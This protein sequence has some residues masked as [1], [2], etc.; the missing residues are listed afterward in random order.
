MAV[1]RGPLN[2]RRWS[3]RW[4][5]ATNDAGIPIIVPRPV[6]ASVPSRGV[7]TEQNVPLEPTETTVPV[8]NTGRVFDVGAVL[9]RLSGVEAET[10]RTGFPEVPRAEAEAAAADLLGRVAQSGAV[11]GEQQREVERRIEQIVLG[12]EP[13]GIQRG[14]STLVGLLPDV[15]ERPLREGTA[16]AGR[17]LGQAV[18]VPFR[19]VAS[20]AK[21]ITDP[22]VEGESASLKEFVTQPFD[23]NNFNP[24]YKPIEDFADVVF[25]KDLSTNRVVQTL[26]NLLNF[27][28]RVGADPT[29]YVGLAPLKYQGAAGRN[30]AAQDFLASRTASLLDEPTRAQLSA[31]IYRY[32]P[33]A[34]PTNVRRGLTEEGLF[35]KAGVR[36]AGGVV[37]GTE[38]LGGGGA[39]ALG[40]FRAGLGD[41]FEGVPATA[42]TPASRQGLVEVARGT[43]DD[44]DRI[45]AAFATQNAALRAKA[46]AGQF[47]GALATRYQPLARALSRLNE[48][49]MSVLVDYAEG[50]IEDLATVPQN[51]RDLAGLM[52]T[53]YDESLGEYNARRIAFS[54]ANGLRLEEVPRIQNFVHRTLTDQAR[55]FTQSRRGLEA[56]RRI[57]RDFGVDLPV[58]RG[59][60]GF[61]MNR[62]IKGSFLGRKLETGPVLR[63]NA[64]GSVVRAGTIREINDI[65]LDELGFKLFDDRP[66]NVLASYLR[67]LTTQFQREAFI[68]DLFVNR[69]SAVAPL[70]G[71]GPTSKAIRSV[72]DGYTK[73]LDQLDRQIA[74]GVGRAEG[75][76][77]RTL[78]RDLVKDVA[79]TTRQIT[80]PLFGQ[81]RQARAAVRRLSAGLDALSQ[82]IA[83]VKSSAEFRRLELDQGALAVLEPLE[84]R[85]RVLQDAID[86]G[87]GAQVAAREWLLKR[88]TELFPDALVRPSA[89]AQLAD[90]ILRDAESRLSGA[91]RAGVERRAGAARE[92]ASPRPAVEVAGETT[93]LPAARAEL[94]R[95]VSAYKKEQKKYRQAIDNDPTL[96]E[97]GSLERKQARQSAKLDAKR[98]ISGTFDLWE[99]TVG[100]LWRADIASIRDLLK[101]IPR[102]DAGGRATSEWLNHVQETFSSLQVAGLTEGQQDALTRVMSQLYGEEAALAKVADNI[103]WGAEL[104]DLVTRGLI[105]TAYVEDIRQGWKTIRDLQVQVS[106]EMAEQIEGIYSGLV[107]DLDRALGQGTTL[108]GD[109]YRAV[110]LYFKSTA[111][112]SAAFTVR[113]AITATWN[114]WV[115]GV[116]VAQLND[117]FGFARL[118]KQHG[119]EGAYRR[120]PEAER[121]RFRAAMDAVYATGG[122]KNVDEI[123]PVVGRAARRR[124][125]NQLFDK[126]AAGLDYVFRP[127]AGRL[128]AWARGKNESVEIA[129]ARLPLALN[130][131]DQGYSTAVNAARI[132]RTQFDYTDLSRLDETLKLIIPFWVFA[133]RNIPLQLVNRA[134]VPGRYAAYDRAT[135]LEEENPNLAA[136]R[137]N[138]NP[139]PLFGGVLDL[140]LPMSTLEDQF[141][142]LTSLSGLL[143]QTYPMVRSPIEFAT[144]QRIA[145]GSAYPYGE[146]FEPLR[147]SV[148]DLPAT[149][150]ALLTGGTQRNVEG[151][152]VAPSRVSGPIRSS[153][154]AFQ[155]IQ[156]YGALLIMAAGGDETSQLNRLVGAEE[157]FFDR[158]LQNLAAQLSGFNYYVPTPED[159]S[160]ESR[161]MIGQTG[162]L[163]REL[164]ELGVIP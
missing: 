29:T 120:V 11:G 12:D 105:D 74:S 65:S 5:P 140:D 159:I 6:S 135:E 16:A 32:G 28:V 119:L 3:T 53:A 99:N 163:E 63:T 125:K 143:G 50:G 45:L 124:F 154:P 115:N 123:F 127:F 138:R 75:A 40:R 20:Y 158:D 2:D 37:P 80:G 19:A 111:V 58:M 56:A 141:A 156:R 147:P 41:V 59:Q 46:D 149:V 101:D 76:A 91:A 146:G 17:T 131:V 4:E 13:T 69:P 157:R 71:T 130:G 67:S 64:D 44:P 54:E 144:G 97:Y 18:Q 103:Q 43:T 70:L 117:A 164:R 90:D 38:A 114:N 14:L 110:G 148:G 42:I 122:G 133:S 152:L 27:V 33:E 26:D 72:V 23:F 134:L 92:A 15:V 132:A 25:G 34:L 121:A 150:G 8:A 35:P 106:P 155:N 161:R 49:E 96:K 60:Q 51:L 87:E 84:A 102:A 61:T 85:I 126:S 57:A 139:I 86:R 112:L 9:S 104:D 21:E 55:E 142:N 89:P 160:A 31:N 39:V 66:A 162:E 136:Y 94:K 83:A 7:P 22:F 1:T 48:Q 24:E 88:H 109:M 113:N 137:S 116:T 30:A 128:S 36:I 107:D 93:T 47:G 73:L 145:F 62:T 10:G 68:A 95:T 129:V 52:R 153:F 151:E 118:V 77:P 108:L 78:G 81:S 98:A 79:D 100:D 82:Q